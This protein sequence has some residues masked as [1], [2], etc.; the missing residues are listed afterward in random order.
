[1]AP[2]DPGTNGLAALYAMEGNVQDTSGKGNNGTASG[3]PVYVQGPAGYG[4]ALSFDG[5]NDYVDLPIGTLV[6]SLTDVTIATQVKI[7]QYRRLL[8]ADLRL[9]HGHDELHVPHAPHGHDRSR[10]IRHPD[11]DRQ[12]RAVRHERRPPCLRAGT[13]WPS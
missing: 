9:R 13:T 1:M 4:K 3:D 11:R 8:A 5:L 6:S 12:R 7:R 2:A 10:A